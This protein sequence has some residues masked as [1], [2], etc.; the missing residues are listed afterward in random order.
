[1]DG[2]NVVYGEVDVET[3]ATAA[4][5]SSRR[6]TPD[7]LVAIAERLW[8][9]AR[10]ARGETAPAPAAPK[11]RRAPDMSTATGRAAARAQR[12]P[13]PA[14]TAATTATTATAEPATAEPAKP[15]GPP[16]DKEL[17]KALD[18]LHQA[19]PDFAQSFPLVLRWMVFAGEFNAE[20]FREF[21]TKFAAAKTKSRDEFRELQVEYPVAIYKSHW[22]KSNP[23]AH[24]DKTVRDR[25]QD[26]RSQLLKQLKEEDEL[27]EKS[28]KEAEAEV[29]R[30]TAENAADRRRLLLERLRE[31]NLGSESAP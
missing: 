3:E 16:S 27:F 4:V 6:A 21:L 29:A 30:V 5:D 14:A 13:K 25:V 20:V 18:E 2:A 12:A 10:R 26:F 31:M 8:E 9:R 11:R 15:K 19:E 23:G 24:D 1:M 28:V 22:A 17:S 7:E